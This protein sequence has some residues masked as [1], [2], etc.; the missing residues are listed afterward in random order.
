MR[1]SVR[2][3]G[4]GGSRVRKHGHWDEIPGSGMRQLRTQPPKVELGIQVKIRQQ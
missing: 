1:N 3:R 2:K 4:G